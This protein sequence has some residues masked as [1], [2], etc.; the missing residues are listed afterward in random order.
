MTYPS[1]PALKILLI[2]DDAGVREVLVQMLASL[3]HLVLATP[4]GREGLTR[5]EAGD[6]VD[7]VLTDLK[8]PGMTGWDVVKRVKARWPHLH[9]GIITG[10]PE[11][12][13]EE[14]EPVDFVIQKPVR[15]EGLR[16][17]LTGVQA[18]EGQE[19]SHP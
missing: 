8:M 1:P 15:L 18:T 17:A 2:E 13:R 10:T 9:V 11:L 7:L 12:L 19:R 6:S 3:G 16:Q 14:R 4:G 5:L